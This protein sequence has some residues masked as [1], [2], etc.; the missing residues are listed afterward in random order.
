MEIAVEIQH[1]YVAD[2]VVELRGPTGAT[3]AIHRFAGG[4]RR[5]L[6]RTYTMS[7]NRTLQRAFGS[8]EGQGEW[9]MSVRDNAEVDT[10]TFDAFELRLTCTPPSQAS[11]GSTGSGSLAQARGTSADLR[12]PFATR[13]QRVVGP[14]TRPNPYGPGRTPQSEVLD[15]WARSP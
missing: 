14:A 4:A 8:T 5:N 2:L 6:S 11:A 12:N 15:P 3:A 13:T 9:T 1:S 10:G 7:Q